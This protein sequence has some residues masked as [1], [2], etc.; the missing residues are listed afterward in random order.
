[1]F[2][3]ETNIANEAGRNKVASKK[4]STMHHQR[5]EHE[6]WARRIASSRPRRAARA[7]ISSCR[8]RRTLRRA[9]IV[10]VEVVVGGVEARQ[11][12]DEVGRQDEKKKLP[13]R[14][15][16]FGA[17]CRRCSSGELG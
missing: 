10:N 1:M 12:A 15:S 7:P 4:V 2:A 6:Q 3:V 9:P 16:D 11:Q 14:G 5:R 17:S 8:R 13:K